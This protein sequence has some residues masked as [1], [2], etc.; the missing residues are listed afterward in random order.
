[1]FYFSYPDNCN[2]FFAYKNITDNYR[3]FRKAINLKTQ[4]LMP[5]KFKI[6]YPVIDNPNSEKSITKV[7]NIITDEVDK[8]FRIQVLRP[9]IIDFQEVLGTYEVTLNKNGILSILF[10]LYVYEKR[11]AHGFTLYSSVTVNVENGELYSFND[12]FNP[13]MYYIPILNK[14]AEKYIK[15]NNILLINKYNGITR[16]QQY[17]LTNNSLVLYYQVYEYTPYVYGLFKI[18]IPY[19]E[20]RNIIG[21]MGPIPKILS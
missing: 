4:N 11:A 10:D 8:L 13:K 5:P 7:N 14:L 20:I 6:S 12:L 21:P 16:E 1:M 3:N 17:Y 2:G 19:D 9:E 18:E 15:E